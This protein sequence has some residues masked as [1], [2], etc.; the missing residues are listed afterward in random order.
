MQ[1]L[2]QTNNK[3]LGKQSQKNGAKIS[4]VQQVKVEKNT[5]A[6][7][8]HD[9]QITT[10]MEMVTILQQPKKWHIGPNI[11]TA[12]MHRI[13]LGRD[14]Y[15]IAFSILIIEPCYCFFYY[16]NLVIQLCNCVPRQLLTETKKHNAH[17]IVWHLL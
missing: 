16:C 7:R 12:S 3:T 10:V 9:T 2:Y 11:F 17:C 13:I 4:W 15:V 6:K 1:K 5:S 14:K 8:E